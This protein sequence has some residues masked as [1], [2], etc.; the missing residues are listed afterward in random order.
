MNSWKTTV[1]GLVAAIGAGI[2]AAMETGTLDPATLPPWLK[3]MAA[4]ASVIG[5]ACL[6]VFARDNNKSSED[7]GAKPAPATGGPRPP[8]VPVVLAG[9]ILFAGAGCYTSDPASRTLVSTVLTVDA[10]MKGWSDF[11]DKGN[12][13]TEQEAAVK[14]AYETYQHAQALAETAY[15]AT[16]VQTNAPFQWEK[17]AAKLREAEVDILALVA[18]FKGP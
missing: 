13:T 7:V 2:L 16:L 5:T 15:F 1:F 17:A 10:A 9:L 6:G 14:N 11:V 8:F 3:G 4:L 12:A 18:K